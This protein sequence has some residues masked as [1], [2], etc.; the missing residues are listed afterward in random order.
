MESFKSFENEGIHEICNKFT[1]TRLKAARA[2]LDWCHQR[3]ADKAIVLLNAVTRLK[4]AEVDSR[5]GT[6]TFLPRGSYKGGIDFRRSDAVVV[7]GGLN[8]PAVSSP[9]CNSAA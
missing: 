3:L 6:L 8:A 2:L 9:K 4:K 7:F 5:L 1:C